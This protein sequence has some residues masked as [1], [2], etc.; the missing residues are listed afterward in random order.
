MNLDLSE[1]QELLR[2]SFEELFAAESSPERVRA[3]EPLGFD[4]GLWKQ[5]VETGAAFMRVPESQGGSEAGLLDAALVCELAGRHLASAPLVESIAASRLL[6]ELPGEVAG[7]ALQ[8]VV[9]TGSVP[10]L[11]VSE[12]WE[13]QLP[14]RTYRSRPLSLQPCSLTSPPISPSV[15]KPAWAGR[16]SRAP[17]PT[18]IR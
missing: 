6:A 5:L 18:T 9:G 12:P 4:A 3:A 2:E 14:R 16:S 8:Q 7:A 13:G 10:T 15:C 17:L 11:A 1:E